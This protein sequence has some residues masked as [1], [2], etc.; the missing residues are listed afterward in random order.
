MYIN[1]CVDQC[2]ICGMVEC[3]SDLRGSSRHGLKVILG[4]DLRLW[5]GKG[6]V[7][8]HGCWRGGGKGKGG[9]T[10]LLCVHVWW[11]GEGRVE[12]RGGG[13]GGCRFATIRVG[14]AC[15]KGMQTCGEM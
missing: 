8:R 5:N 14:L 9:G 7:C 15:Q 12:G 13:M 1:M 6:C 3:S 2:I 11:G 10:V 4:T